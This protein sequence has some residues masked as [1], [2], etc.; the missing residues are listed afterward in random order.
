MRHRRVY[1]DTS[2][3]G[4]VF[5]EEFAIP[6]R[7]F[8]QQVKEGRFDLVSSALV[9]DEIADATQRVRIFFDTMNPW[10]TFSDIPE[11][12]VILRNAYL[13]SGIVGTSSRDDAQHAALAVVL[14]CWTIVSWNF[15]HIVHVRK[16]PLYNGI[17]QAQ[18]YREIAIHTPQ[19]V[20]EYEEKEF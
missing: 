5:D 2:V 1:A 18:G 17:N 16:I 19:E 10:I 11:E 14:D 9:A 13:E 15:K 12:A 8:F 3:F 20:I 6:S 4:G 7:I